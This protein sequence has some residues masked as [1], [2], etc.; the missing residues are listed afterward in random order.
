[1]TKVMISN[2]RPDTTVLPDQELSVTGTAS[3]RGWPEP[4]AIDSAVVRVDGGPP[5]DAKLTGSPAGEESVYTFEA[6]VRAPS[7]QGPHRI[8]VTAVNDQGRS[9][10]ESVTVF[11]GAGPLFTEFAGTATLVTS[12]TDPRLAMPPSGSMAGAL[13]FSFDHTTARIT[14]LDDVP[15]GP[16]PGIPLLGSLMVTISRTPGEPAAA[17]DPGTGA[18]TLPIALHFAYDKTVPGLLEDS[19]VDFGFRTGNPLTTGTATSPSG[20]LSATGTP[21]NATTGAIT[22]VGASR[23]TGG[24]PLAG[25]ECTLT[26]AATFSTI[27]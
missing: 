14:R 19:D 21:R 3:D 5:M 15:V 24:P 25:L 10:T 13:E 9:A 6:K 27:P 17:F 23:F 20:L 16:I 26:V 18:M 1:M 4:I 11:V 22:L 12:S 8:A 2:P 7:A